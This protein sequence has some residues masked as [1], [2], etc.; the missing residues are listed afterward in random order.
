MMSVVNFNKRRI[1]ENKLQVT[2]PSSTIRHFVSDLNIGLINLSPDYQRG[3]KWDAKRC[4]HLIQ[5]VLEKSYIPPLLYYTLQLDEKKEKFRY[6]CVDGQN[7]SNTIRA[8]VNGEFIL[9]N[10]KKILPYWLHNE[11]NTYVFYQKNKNTEDFEKEN[12][13][14]TIDYFTEDEK[15]VFDEYVLDINVINSPMTYEERCQLFTN[16]QTGVPNRNSD[17]DKNRLEC[18]LIHCFT[19]ER[20]V[21][22]Y[23][24]PY[25]QL[26]ITQPSNYTTYHMM[27]L[28]AIYKEI[29]KEKN[30]DNEVNKDIEDYILEEVMT[31]DTKYKKMIGKTS[32]KKFT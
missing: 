4:S 24:K 25:I 21:A 14:L 13:H 6:E 8:F 10:N 15:S 20:I 1:G 32:T 2:K 3:F 12:E 5:A 28:F 29:N 9:S 19:E 23:E 16:L 11:T 31:L 30:S 7:R 22:L 17:F 26:L 18:T 27:R